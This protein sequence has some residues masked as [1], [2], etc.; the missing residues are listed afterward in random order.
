MAKFS[1][2]LALT[3]AALGVGACSA[4]SAGPTLPSAGA[5]PTHAGVV[6][7]AG[8]GGSGGGGGY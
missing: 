3:L 7:G 8:S 5:A 2:A 4:P 6:G 1:V